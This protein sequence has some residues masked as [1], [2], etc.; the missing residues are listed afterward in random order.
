MAVQPQK[1]A[2][3]V[4][5]RDGERRQVHRAKVGAPVLLQHAGRLH[6]EFL[7][8][9]VDVGNIP[10]LYFKLSNHLDPSAMFFWTRTRL[11]TDPLE[12]VVFQ[13]NNN[14]DRNNTD[15]VNEFIARIGPQEH[16]VPLLT[17]LIRNG[18]IQLPE[19]I[20]SNARSVGGKRSIKRSRRRRSRRRR[21][22]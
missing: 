11:G 18:A 19:R 20:V 3:V 15:A 6:N 16:L 22:R 1:V 4:E 17:A 8:T 10:L 13:K 21:T 12:V 7:K 9:I 5:Q 2:G 14:D